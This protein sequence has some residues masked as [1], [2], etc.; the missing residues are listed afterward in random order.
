M[1]N[2][3]RRL[4]K[5]IDQKKKDSHSEVNEDVDYGNDPVTVHPKS[6]HPEEA[7]EEIQIKQH[8]RR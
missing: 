5:A 3:M 6:T 4:V 7:W 1:L 8:Y 2:S